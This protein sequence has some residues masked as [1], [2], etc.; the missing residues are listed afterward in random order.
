[1]P[2]AI[3]EVSA[4]NR[5]VSGPG[6]QPGRQRNRFPAL[7]AG[8]F[9][10]PKIRRAIRILFR[11]LRQS[12]LH[13]VL[14]DIFL[15]R[16]KALPIQDPDF[17]KSWRPDLSCQ[18]KLFVTSERI[19][20][21]DELNRAFNARIPVNSEEHMEMVRHHHEFVQLELAGQGV[22]PQDVNKKLGF[23][24]RLKKSPIHIGLTSGEKRPHTRYDL[25]TVRL[26]RE[27][28]HAQRLKPEFYYAYSPAKA[29]A[30]IRPAPAPQARG[31]RQARVWLA[32]VRRREITEPTAS[33][34]GKRGKE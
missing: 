17:G 30:L 16:Q 6:L 34:V 26:S 24:L 10:S 33:A 28:Y 7:A 27:L 22:G 1:F 8:L 32:G 18:P 3:T 23:V 21:F 13:R 29:G 9:L 15:M 5:F 14:I 31:P 11:A 20:A 2:R 4:K 12:G 19:S 25:P